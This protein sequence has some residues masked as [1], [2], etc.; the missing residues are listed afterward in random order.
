MSLLW[1]GEGL[2]KCIC[3]TICEFVGCSSQLSSEPS[4]SHIWHWLYYWCRYCATW[5]NYYIEY[6]R[7]RWKSNVISLLTI[8]HWPS[9]SVWVLFIIVW[10]DICLW[11]SRPS[12]VGGWRLTEWFHWF[13]SETA[14]DHKKFAPV[15]HQNQQAA[16]WLCFTWKLLPNY[17]VCIY[18]CQNVV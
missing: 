10:Y 6:A 12:A 9:R 11:T 4:W 13:M 14:F 2:D 5:G 15:T 17:C 3:L 16:V 18:V 1:W 7:K 8:R